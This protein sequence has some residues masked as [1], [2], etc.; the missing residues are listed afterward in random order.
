MKYGNKLTTK[1]EELA[2]SKAKSAKEWDF[3]K[4]QVLNCFMVAEKIGNR[5]VNFEEHREWEERLI[6]L[7]IL[8]RKITKPEEQKQKFKDSIKFNVSESKEESAKSK[9]ALEKALLQKAEQQ[10]INT[11]MIPLGYKKDENGKIVRILPEIKEDE[12]KDKL[13]A[14]N[15]LSIEKKK[16]EN[17]KKIEISR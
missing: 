10:Y 7:G 4:E 8:E 13:S 17:K 1:L 11:G 15:N 16:D 6:R 5:N 3:F 2:S 9:V 12:G 14:G